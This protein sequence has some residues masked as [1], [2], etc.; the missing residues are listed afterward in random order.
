EARQRLGVRLD[1]VRIANRLQLLGRC[2]QQLLDNQVRDLVHARAS[3][4]RQ[5]RQLEVQSLEL[6]PADVLESLTE[7]DDGGN[8]AARSEPRAEP[9]DFLADNGFGARDLARAAR[10]VLA[11]RRLEIVDVVEKDLLD[12]SRRRVDVARTAISL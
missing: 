11:H 8:R 12:L 7:R 5:R 6:G 4:W 2:E 10:E 1:G 3:V 9:I